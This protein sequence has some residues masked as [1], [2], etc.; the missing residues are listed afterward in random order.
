[1]TVNDIISL[2][3]SVGFPVVMCGALFWYMIN[4]TREHAAE[5]KEMKDA[6]NALNVAITKLTEKIK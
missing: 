3:Q 1:M 2:I 6:I 4:Q 5:S